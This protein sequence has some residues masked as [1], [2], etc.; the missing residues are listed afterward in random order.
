MGKTHEVNKAITDNHMEVL[1]EGDTKQI[2]KEKLIQRF[3][4][5]EK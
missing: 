5:F 4:K 1:V 3:S 2:K